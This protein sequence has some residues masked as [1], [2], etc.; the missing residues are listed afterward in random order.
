M[1]GHPAARMRWFGETVCVRV[2]M[3]KP[4]IGLPLVPE[5]HLAFEKMIGD[6]EEVSE[7]RRGLQGEL[8]GTSVAREGRCLL[9]WLSLAAPGRSL[10]PNGR[11]GRSLRLEV[12]AV[13]DGSSEKAIRHEYGNRICHNI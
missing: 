1:S 10:G 6:D 9:G 2:E 13:H 11:R 4:V 7:V 3:S 12:G 5:R 8:N